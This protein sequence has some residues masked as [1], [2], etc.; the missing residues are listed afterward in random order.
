MLT[1]FLTI[2]RVIQKELCIVFC[3]SS[4]CYCC[5]SIYQIKLF[6]T[7]MTGMIFLFGSVQWIVLDK[8]VQYVHFL[9]R[10]LCSIR[11]GTALSTTTTTTTT[12]TAKSSLVAYKDNYNGHKK[13]ERHCKFDLFYINNFSL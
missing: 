7:N 6:N 2:N 4:F 3:G 5:E 12:T 9:F 13:K 1:R 8:S 10:S 11:Y